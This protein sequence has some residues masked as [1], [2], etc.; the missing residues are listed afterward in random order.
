MEFQ[1][2]GYYVYR[3]TRASYNRRPD[4]TEFMADRSRLHAGVTLEDEKQI[5]A[6]DFVHRAP[7]LVEYPLSM[8]NAQFVNHLFDQAG[9]MPF[10]VERQQLIADMNIGK[11]RSRALRDVIEIQEFKTREYNAAFVT[12]QYFGYL[13]RN[14]DQGGYDFWLNVLNNRVPNNYLAMVC[15][16]LTSREYQERFSPVVTRANSECR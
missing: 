2:T 8:T 3:L 14:P 12:M 6:D 11:S 7:F 15:A 1:D 9:L 5:L 4:F 16:F 10:T 13:R